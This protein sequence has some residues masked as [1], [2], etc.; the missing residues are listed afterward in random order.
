MALFFIP[1]KIDSVTIL[2]EK[3][4]TETTIRLSDIGKEDTGY[5]IRQKVTV[6]LDELV[7][8]AETACGVASDVVMTAMDVVPAIV[9]SKEHPVEYS[10]E[11]VL[12]DSS[13]EEV[14]RLISSFR[15]K[16]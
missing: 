14:D 11:T 5:F 7:E 3:N 15:Y 13:E 12:Y 6:M 10:L 2:T 8:C 1:M 4:H 16:L 9:Y